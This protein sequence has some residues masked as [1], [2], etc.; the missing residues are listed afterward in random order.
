MLLC[1]KDNRSKTCPVLL[2]NFEKRDTMNDNISNRNF[3]LK[4]QKVIMDY[5]PSFTRNC[6]SSKARP[7]QLPELQIKETQICPKAMTCR[8]SKFVPGK[9]T[10]EHFLENIDIDSELRNIYRKTTRCDSK[11][12]T[13]N[14]YSCHQFNQELQQSYSPTHKP[15]CGTPLLTEAFSRDSKDTL[16][17]RVETAYTGE[18]LVKMRYI[19]PVKTKN[20]AIDG[21]NRCTVSKRF[22]ACPSSCN[23]KI[24]QTASK[25]CNSKTLQVGPIRRD[26]SCELFWNNVTKRKYIT[27]KPEH[28]YFWNQ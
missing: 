15:R 14:T 21:I 8:E 10:A 12:Y 2:C 7:A 3:P 19:N 25:T 22:E 16:G 27:P 5:R 11:K 6:G 23:Q 17:K 20:I 26:Q 4:P 13:P 9:G 24:L 28:G 1:G 18:S